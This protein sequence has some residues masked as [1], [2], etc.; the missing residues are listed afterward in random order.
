M[1]YVRDEAGVDDRYVSAG[2]F[3]LDVGGERV[4][5]RAS[6]AAPYDPRA[7]RVKS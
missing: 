3:A 2:A 5:A 7:A 1:G 4:A 6:L